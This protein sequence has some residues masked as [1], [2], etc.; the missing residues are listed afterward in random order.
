MVGD[1]MN[2]A[3]GDPERAKELLGSDNGDERRIR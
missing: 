1:V 3:K 2:K